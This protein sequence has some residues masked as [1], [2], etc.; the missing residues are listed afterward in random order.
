MQNFVRSGFSAEQ[1]WQRI[2]LP[3]D[4]ATG[5]FCITWRPTVASS[6]KIETRR[7]CQ[8]GLAY[9]WSALLSWC[10]KS[11]V[12]RGIVLLSAQGVVALPLM[13]FFEKRPVDLATGLQARDLCLKPAQ[14]CW[15]TGT[16]LSW[17]DI[18]RCSF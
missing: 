5:L 2:D 6:E 12:D 17:N 4:A 1:F 15:W 10:S 14:C 3:P 16:S 13:Y 8:M 7:I 18:S 11:K 9:Q